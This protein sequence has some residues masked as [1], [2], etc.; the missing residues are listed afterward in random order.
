M[1]CLSENPPT[2]LAASTRMM[3]ALYA[4]HAFWMWTA[5]MKGLHVTDAFHMILGKL[6][7]QSYR[8]ST[9]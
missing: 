2:D 7:S 9:I 8:V 4:V 3:K 5:E 6:S 1:F